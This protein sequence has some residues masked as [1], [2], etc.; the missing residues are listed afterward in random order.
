MG[1]LKGG[2]SDP[3][4]FADSMAAAIEGELN[5][6]LQA[7]GKQPLPADGT[8]DA[9]HDR[10]RFIAAIARGVILHMQQNPEAFEVVFTSVPGSLHTADFAATVQVHG[11]DVP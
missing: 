3:T 7:D 10:R 11:S 4:G 9:A 5:E 2:A 8:T 1:Y 6:L